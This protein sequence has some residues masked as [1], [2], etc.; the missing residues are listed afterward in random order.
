MPFWPF[1]H[2]NGSTGIGAHDR[3][4][5][6]ITQTEAAETKHNTAK[7]GKPNK[8]RHNTEAGTDRAK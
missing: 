2:G 4:R 6:M 3:N 5:I 7:A 8:G 1:L